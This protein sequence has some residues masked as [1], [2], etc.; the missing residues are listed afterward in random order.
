MGLIYDLTGRPVMPPNIQAYMD[1]NGYELYCANGHWFIVGDD[2]ELSPDLFA[3]IYNRY[4][5]EK[6]SQA[7]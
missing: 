2:V 7:P 4:N 1:E 5:S 3:S 6:G